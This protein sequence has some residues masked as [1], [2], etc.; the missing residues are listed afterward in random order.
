MDEQERNQKM[1]LFRY[2]LIA[3][4][5]SGTHEAAT[6]IQHFKNVAGKSYQDPTGKTVKVSYHTLERWY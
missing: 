6:L 1:A 5:V 4:V 2:S 3:A